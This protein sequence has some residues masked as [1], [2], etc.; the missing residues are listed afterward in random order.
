MTPD[1]KENN[2]MPL[3][4]GDA[5]SSALYAIAPNCF[6][7]LMGEVHDIERDSRSAESLAKEVAELTSRLELRNN[8]E[9]N[10]QEI[11]EEVTDALHKLGLRGVLGHVVF[12]AAGEAVAN[13]V[14]ARVSRETDKKVR[15]YQVDVYAKLVDRLYANIDQFRDVARRIEDSQAAIRPVIVTNLIATW[16]ALFLTALAVARLFS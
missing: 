15:E 13:L 8:A 9:A 4:C 1:P 11:G 6:N 16:I 12:N 14:E 5:A 3:F 7:I 2:D 10:R